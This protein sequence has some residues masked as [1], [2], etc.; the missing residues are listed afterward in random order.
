MFGPESIIRE[1]LLAMREECI[2][3]AAELAVE[4][5]TH[6]VAEIVHAVIEIQVLLQFIAANSIDDCVV[7]SVVSDA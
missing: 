2:K 5:T 4:G 6:G 7:L 3:E 1:H